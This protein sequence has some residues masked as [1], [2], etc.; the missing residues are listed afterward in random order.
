MLKMPLFNG[1]E[2]MA[3]PLQFDK[4]QLS[5]LVGLSLFR[6]GDGGGCELNVN[7]SVLKKLYLV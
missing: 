1:Q 5:G 3:V 4:L 6:V 2:W 7:Y